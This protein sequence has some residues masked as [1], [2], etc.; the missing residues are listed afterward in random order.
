MLGFAMRAGK[1]TVGTEMTLAGVKKT[2]KGRVKLVL[3]TET[4]SA[5]T[6]KKITGKC[7]F[8]GVEYIITEISASTLGER[9]GKLYAPSAVGITDDGFAKEIKQCVPKSTPCKRDVITKR[10]EV[11]DMETGDTY[12]S[13]ISEDNSDI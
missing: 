7:E 10:K 4:A 11:S 9:L 1:V 8:Y 12:G 13:G 6:K 5:G 2:G 3:I